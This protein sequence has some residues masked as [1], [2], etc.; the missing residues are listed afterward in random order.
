MKVPEIQ[1]R[2][3]FLPSD[4]QIS[5]DLCSKSEWAQKRCARWPRMYYSCS[6]RSS[7]ACTRYQARANMHWIW[8]T[9]M[10]DWLLVWLNIFKF[11]CFMQHRPRTAKCANLQAVPI[12][13]LSL[14]KHWA[15]S[16]V[17]VLVMS[18]HLLVDVVELKLSKLQPWLNG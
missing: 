11:A 15:S 1:R 8:L 10:H 17:D 5:I 13:K 2:I 12:C 7:A 9:E 16:N 18:M 3:I 14:Y 4:A 6:Q